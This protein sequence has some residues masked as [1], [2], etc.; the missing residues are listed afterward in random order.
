MPSRVRKL[1]T[2]GHSYV[3]ALNRRLANEIARVGREK[4]EVTVI[5]PTSFHSGVRPICLEADAAE[6]CK[7]ESVAAYLARQRQ[8]FFY[9]PRLRNILRMPWD[10]VHCWEEP[11][12]FA[13]WQVASWTRRSTPTVFYAMQN[14]S[15]KYP[16]LFESIENFCVD[17]CTGWIAVGE[18]VRDTLVNRGYGR[19]PHRVLPLGVDVSC[20]RPDRASGREVRKGVYSDRSDAPVIGFLGRFVEEKG[21]SL[22]MRALDDLSSEWRALFVGAGPMEETLRNWGRRYGDRVKVVTGVNHSQVPAY[23]NAMSILCAPSQT[24]PRWR[25]QF[26]RMLIEAFACGIP[27]V[28]SDSG[29]IP[30]VIGDA[31]VIVSESSQADWTEAIA[32]LIDDPE[33]RSELSQRGLERAHATHAWPIVAGRHIDFFE[34]LLDS[35]AQ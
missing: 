19:R 15:K 7:L 32:G 3:V 9:G 28:A 29:E 23:L 5:A 24:T 12:I 1:L 35:R 25:E 14:I 30:Y 11:Y 26:G 34:E 4:W 16:R 20:F 13:S 8:I 22:L 33:R 31:G 27:V 6:T 10:L 18:V 21:I 2:I 17:R